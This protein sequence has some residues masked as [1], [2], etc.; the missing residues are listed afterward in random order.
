MAEADEL[1]DIQQRLA[2]VET[3]LEQLFEHLK[4]TP[5]APS[6]EGGAA[7]PIADAE[8]EDLIAKGNKAQA[9]KRYH[10]LNDVDLDEARK[11]VDALEAEE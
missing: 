3:R 2:L 6:G 10:E 4:I 1:R 11:A 5:R 9:I 7:E 8:I